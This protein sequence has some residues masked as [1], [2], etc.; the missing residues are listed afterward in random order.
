MDFL[1][2]YQ[3]RRLRRHSCGHLCSPHP[4]IDVLSASAML[5]AKS[6]GHEVDPNAT[7]EK[8]LP[9]PIWSVRLLAAYR[10]KIG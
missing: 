8:L 7:S 5:S 2:G 4:P 1:R 3:R 6:L 9:F 10:C